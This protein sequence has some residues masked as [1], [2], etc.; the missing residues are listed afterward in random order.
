MRIPLV[1]GNWKMYKTLS[2]TKEF[3][4]HFVKLLKEAKKQK[5]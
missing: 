3:M 4:N 2:E 1:A 5:F